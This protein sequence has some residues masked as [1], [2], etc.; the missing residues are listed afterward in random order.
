MPTLDPW[1]PG[2]TFQGLTREILRDGDRDDKKERRKEDRRNREERSRE[3]LVCAVWRRQ[4]KH[5]LRGLKVA[6][7]GFQPCWPPP[8]SPP[9]LA[10][11]S[12][13]KPVSHCPPESAIPTPGLSRCHH[14]SLQEG[15][16]LIPVT[17][18]GLDFAW[19]YRK[20]SLEHWLPE[21]PG[22]S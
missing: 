5:I 9:P 12:I 17:T 11:N 21:V 13:R 3:V 20:R 1:I 8:L 16:S 15:H 19:E 4:Q 7:S 10:H 18:L 14:G 22:V 2:L 6:K